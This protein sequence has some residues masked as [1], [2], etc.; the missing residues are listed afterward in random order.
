MFSFTG[1][2]LK[3][4]LSTLLLFQNPT[5]DFINQFYS[6]VAVLFSVSLR[7]VYSTAVVKVRAAVLL[8][9]AFLSP[10]ICT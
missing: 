3:D 2:K 5:F 9:P 7:S 10:S 8:D 1:L 4:I 6:V